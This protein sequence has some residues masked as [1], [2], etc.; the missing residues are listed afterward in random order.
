MGLS[1]GAR[2][3]SYS[4]AYPVRSSENHFAAIDI[5]SCSRIPRRYKNWGRKCWLLEG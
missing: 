2:S 1:A 3:M 5:R 4:V